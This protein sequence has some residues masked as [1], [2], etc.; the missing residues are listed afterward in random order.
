MMAAQIQQHLAV[1][2]GWALQRGAIEKQFDFANYTQTLA[3]VNGVAGIAEDQDHHPEINF[4]YNRCTLR[5]DTHSVGGISLN[6]IICAA[7]VEALLPV[8]LA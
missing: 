1:L 2:P 7:R 6:D 5:L 8:S 3:F 4:T